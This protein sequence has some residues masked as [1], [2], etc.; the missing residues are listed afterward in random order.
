MSTLTR[1]L[2][3][4]LFALFLSAASRAAEDKRQDKQATPAEQYKVL[5][6]E[7]QDARTALSAARLGKVA[8]RFL[9]LAEKNP[10]DPIAVDALVQV[11]AVYNSSAHPAGKDSP[12][13]RALA[14]LLRDHIRSAKLGEVC[15]RI[16]FGFRQ[17][18]ETFLR[19]VLDRNPHKEVQAL[20]RLSLA[21]FL[22]NRSQ[23]L[24]LVKEQPELA[25]QYE[26]LFGKDYLKEL[27]GQDRVK[28]VKEVEAL[29]EHAATQYGDVKIAALW[30]GEK[31]TTVGERAKSELFKLRHLAV[32][33]EAPDI[34]GE[35]QDGKR[36]KLSDYRGKVVLL[37][38]W[39]EF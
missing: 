29:F 21:Q 33:R 27:Q 31:P 13:G 19:T 8:L 6:K 18:Y 9:E 10:K 5:L 39:H 1:R 23:R 34:E 24:D 30:A 3:L 37:D 20:A 12:G 17:E 25:K 4:P 7:F 36:F 35:D 32:G 28:A 16:S 22:N 26:A 11:V 15:Q 2:I 14:L 38:F